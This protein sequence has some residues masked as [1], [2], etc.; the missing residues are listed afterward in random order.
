M[1]VYMCVCVGRLP[2]RVWIHGVYLQRSRAVL[3]LHPGAMSGEGD[4][5]AVVLHL[6]LPLHLS[7]SSLIPYTH[8]LSL[9]F[10]SS[11]SPSLPPSLSLSPLPPFL[12]LSFFSLS[13]LSN[14]LTQFSHDQICDWNAC[15]LQW[16]MC[17]HACIQ[18]YETRKPLD[19]GLIF[20]RFPDEVSSNVHACRDRLAGVW[21]HHTIHM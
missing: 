11:L 13:A 9:S 5:C 4:L 18:V 21:I 7:F 12:T 10:P 19:L 8:T 3:E 17:T 1:C 16:N 6:E 20:D 14:Y 2:Q 15:L